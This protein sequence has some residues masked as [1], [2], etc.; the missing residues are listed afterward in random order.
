MRAELKRIHSPD[1]YDLVSYQPEGPFG[2]LIQMMVGPEDTPN[3][4][5][6]DTIVCSSDWVAAHTAI[7]DLI[8]DH[9]ILMNKYNYQKLFLQIQ[10]FCQLQEGNTWQEVALKISKI[11]K[12]EF[13]DY[14]EY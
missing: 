2:I 9:K 12:W 7:L 4:E 5:A 6:F 10:E 3:E 13:A 14:K 1:V 8:G 11:G